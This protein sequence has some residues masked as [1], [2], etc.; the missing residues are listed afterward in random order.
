MLP[1]T[2]GV[3]TLFTVIKGTFGL[4]PDPSPAGEQLPLALVDEYYGEPGSSSV[5]IPSDISLTKPGTDVLLQGHAYAPAGRPATQIDV[6][7][8]VGPLQKQVRVFG[9]RY[10]LSAAVGP[11]ISSPEPFEAMPLVWERAYGGID[12]VGSEIQAETRNP[13]GTGFRDPDGASELHGL[14]L[15]NLEDPLHPI[16][17]WKQRP[18][19]A[20]F[21]PVAAHWEPRR[22]YA[23]TYDDRYRQERAPFLPSDFD[24]RFFQVA[25]PGLVA[26]DYLQGGEPVQVSGATPSGVLRFRLPRVALEVSHSL[27]AGAEARPANL[28]TVLLKPDEGVLILVWRSALACDKKALQVREIRVSRLQGT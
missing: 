9:D 1:N 25:P 15:P 16:S 14:K 4:D 10:W 8:S 23:G 28:E 24:R 5:R 19:P 20:C 11:S 2:D 17:S 6:S 18:P 22:S 27:G 21:A 7:L 3:D 12:T 13:V 26:D